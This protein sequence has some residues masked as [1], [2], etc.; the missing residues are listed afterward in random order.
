MQQVMKRTSKEQEIFHMKSSLGL[1]Y[2]V[3]GGIGSY[4]GANLSTESQNAIIDRDGVVNPKALVQLVNRKCYYLSP[5][6]Y[7]L[8]VMDFLEKKY[9]HGK[10]LSANFFTSLYYQAFMSVYQRAD[11][12]I[13]KY[14]NADDFPSDEELLTAYDKFKTTDLPYMGP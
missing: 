14:P 13:R 9:S 6:T 2:Y 4:S 8:V 5:A 3:V 10:T 7:A 1:I 12:D 11:T